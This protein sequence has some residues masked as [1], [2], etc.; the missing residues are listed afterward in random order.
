MCAEPNGTH[1]GGRPRALQVNK[2]LDT[3]ILRDNPLGQVGARRLLRA[4]HDLGGALS[5]LDLMGCT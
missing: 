2:S 1:G 4:V 3:L 5:R